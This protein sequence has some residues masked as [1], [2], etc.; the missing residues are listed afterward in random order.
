M[1]VY[2]HHFAHESQNCLLSLERWWL[3]SLKYVL[4]RLKHLDCL[5]TELKHLAL[6]Q[7][8]C[9]VVQRLKP[10]CLAL[11]ASLSSNICLCV[12]GGPLSCIGAETCC[13]LLGTDNEKTYVSIFDALTADHCVHARSLWKSSVGRLGC[14]FSQD[15]FPQR[16]HLSWNEPRRFVSWRPIPLFNFVSW[17]QHIMDRHR[18]GTRWRDGSFGFPTAGGGWHIDE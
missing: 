16:C 4:A 2:V 5:W 3:S 13:Y 12:H 1:Y 14:D 9:F 18:P 7:V 6:R 10:S 8:N 11:Y 17:F 15:S